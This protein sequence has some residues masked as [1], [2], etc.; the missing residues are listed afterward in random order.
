MSVFRL[1]ADI[2]AKREKF[3][4]SGKLEKFPFD[5]NLILC[6]WDGKF[7]DFVMRVDKNHINNPLLR[8][9]EMLE[10]KDAGSFTVAPFNST[11]PSGKKRFSEINN[12]QNKSAK[13][14][15]PVDENAATLHVRDVY[16][17]V[18][19]KRKSGAVKICL[20]HG[21]FFETIEKEKLI[22]DAFRQV[23]DDAAPAGYFSDKER[24]KIIRIMNSQEIFSATR[25]VDKASVSLRFRVMTQVHELANIMNP[26]KF[27]EIKSNTLNLI[28]PTHGKSEATR[29][30]E[31]DK[32]NAAA[33]KAGVPLKETSKFFIKHPF[34]GY[35]WVLQINL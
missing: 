16:Y 26:K 32:I 11:V 8:G 18:R 33:K 14:I 17:L 23:V 34:N 4:K 24:E 31:A 29:K 2:A 27:A 6:K 20:I 22:K 12:E 15:K 28:V 19:G 1:F 13:L 9:G 30:A 35:F 25:Q 21:S 7:P 5:Y 10:L 3:K